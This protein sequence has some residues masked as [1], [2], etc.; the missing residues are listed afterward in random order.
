[1]AGRFKERPLGTEHPPLTCVEKKNTSFNTSQKRDQ[2]LFFCSF[3]VFFSY[4]SSFLYA[5]SL[6]HFSHLA[7]TVLKPPLSPVTVAHFRRK[8][9]WLDQLFQTF[10]NKLAYSVI[11][12][13]RDEVI[14]RT[15]QK[16]DN[17]VHLSKEKE[18]FGKSEVGSST[19]RN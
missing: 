14:F 16:H 17:N 15:Q 1:M 8:P 9:L 2:L 3:Y 18:K 19:A 4:R 7:R 6:L 10:Q 13:F 11:T 5:S 12:L